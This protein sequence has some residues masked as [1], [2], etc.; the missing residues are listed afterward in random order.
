MMCTRACYLRRHCQRA[1]VAALAGTRGF[2]TSRARTFTPY[3]SERLCWPER[4]ELH[5]GQFGRLAFK[6][7][8]RWPRRQVLRHPAG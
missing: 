4:P 2:R 1:L 3:I 5:D 8:V 7:S 6:T